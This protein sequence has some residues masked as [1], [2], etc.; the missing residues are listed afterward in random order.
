MRSEDPR[1]ALGVG[2]GKF[3]LLDDFFSLVG[4][5]DECADAALVASL[6]YGFGAKLCAAKI[7]SAGW[8]FWPC[9]LAARGATCGGEEPGV[10]RY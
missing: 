7:G 2:G 9:G 6:E 1:P 10:E 4:D 8:G 3:P 5:G